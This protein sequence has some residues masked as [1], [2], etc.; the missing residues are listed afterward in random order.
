MINDSQLCQTIGE[1]PRRIPHQILP[2]LLFHKL[3]NKHTGSSLEVVYLATVQDWRLFF[4]PVCHVALMGADSPPWKTLRE[5]FCAGWTGQFHV[6]YP[7]QPS[8]SV[9]PR[10][11][12]L[13]SLPSAVSLPSLCFPVSRPWQETRLDTCTAPLP[14][15][16]FFLHPV[17][18]AVRGFPLFGWPGFHVCAGRYLGVL[19]R[20]SVFSMKHTAEGNWWGFA[21]TG[22]LHNEGETPP[23]STNLTPPIRLTQG[24]KQRGESARYCQYKLELIH[25]GCELKL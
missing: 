24:W 11:R 25:D 21:A 2:H 9:F 18:Y 16:F 14:F 3:H 12:S 4:L 7:V 8:L 15:S 23:L 22:T 19:T 13:F 20:S 6:L 5:D 10:S 1:A 17:I